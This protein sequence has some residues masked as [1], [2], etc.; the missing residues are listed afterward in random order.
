VES[1]V[2]QAFLEYAYPLLTA[3]GLA[4]ARSLGMIIVSPAFNR[5]GLTGMIRSAVAVVLAIPIAPVIYAGL[6]VTE[7]PTGMVIAGLLVKEMMIGLVIGLLFGIPFWAAEVAGELV[8]LQRGSTM[9]QLLDPLGAGETSISSTL[10]TITLITLFFMSGGFMLMVDG[11]YRSYALWPSLVFTPIVMESTVF[12]VLRVLDRIMQIGVLL[13]A[14]IVVALLVADMMLAYLS[15]MAP[16]L[17]V[18]D[19]SLP[20]KNLLF[21][22]LMVLYVAFL[23]P[24]MLSELGNLQQVFDIVE[25]TVHGG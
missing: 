17:H 10:M 22:F 2:V 8:D 23:V 15:R 24:L 25:R 13:I 7:A 11:Y 14:P 9:A 3:F 5:L 4:V 19:L 20:V 18:F 6:S 16:Q 12:E 1:G 21:S